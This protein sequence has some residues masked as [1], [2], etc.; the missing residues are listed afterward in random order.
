MDTTPVVEKSIVISHN[1][2]RGRGR[3]RGRGLGSGRGGYSG[4]SRRQSDEPEAPRVLHPLQN[5]LRKPFFDTRRDWGEQWQEWDVLFYEER[6]RLRKEWLKEQRD[7]RLE[8]EGLVVRDEDRAELTETSNKGTASSVTSIPVEGDASDAPSRPHRVA[9][10]VYQTQKTPFFDLLHFAAS[11]FKRNRPWPPI[12][13]NLKYADPEGAED[14]VLLGWIWDQFRLYFALLGSTPVWN[15]IEP[16]SESTEDVQ[17]RTQEPSRWGGI[18]DDEDEVKVLPDVNNKPLQPRRPY[19]LL[20]Y[21]PFTITEQAQ[22]DALLALSRFQKACRLFRSVFDIEK[23]VKIFLSSYAYEN[24]LAA[25]RCVVGNGKIGKVV[26]SWLRFLLEGA[27]VTD[28]ATEE[29]QA[30]LPT[31]VTDEQRVPI[32]TIPP[33]LDDLTMLKSLNSQ[34]LLDTFHALVAE[35]KAVPGQITPEDSSQPPYVVLPLR[36][37]VRRAIDVADQSVFELV[38]PHAAKT[39]FPGKLGG[40]CAEKW[41]LAKWNER[42]DELGDGELATKESLD[43]R[44]E[45]LEEGSTCHAVYFGP[46][47]PPG[48][49]VNQHNITVK[50]V[51]EDDDLPNE[52]DLVEEVFDRET[53]SNESVRSVVSAQSSDSDRPSEDITSSP[54]TSV[55]LTSPGAEE[56]LSTPYSIPDEVE[57]LLSRDGGGVRVKQRNARRIAK[58]ERGDYRHQMPDGSGTARDV[59]VG[60]YA[61]IVLEPWL[62]W[63]HNSF[64][65]IVGGGRLEVDGIEVEELGEVDLRLEDIVILVEENV[66]DVS[67]L[68]EGMGMMGTWGKLEVELGDTSGG[69]QDN[70]VAQPLHFWYV[71]RLDMAT[72]SYWVNNDRNDDDV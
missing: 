11:D 10:D 4:D 39:V 37:A 69:K 61:R 72:P 8:S 23:S 2:G 26:K 53:D 6:E 46:I 48:F 12:N 42:Q 31:I 58:I 7:S 44:Q 62:D 63:K 47:P 16:G 1:G 27:G 24:E 50:I 30:D 68:R 5:H 51:K 28:E 41:G 3:G 57:G 64:Q 65:D 13:P 70:E 33:I 67:G 25:S 60:R 15:W 21:V 56:W 32:P 43:F 35:M 29:G 45:G 54:P 52:A 34:R 14:K 66:L 38:V 49:E 55:S 40:W 18:S 71:E 19:A 9:L 22:L 17:D 59:L 36:S 20:N